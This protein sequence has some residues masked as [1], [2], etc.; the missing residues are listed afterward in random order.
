[1][2][3]AWEPTTAVAKAYVDQL[4]RS[5][6]IS[7]ERM[8]AIN[9]ALSKVDSLRTGKE[10]NAKAA[11]DQL[12]AVA[13]QVEADGKSK[14]GVDAKRYAALADTLRGRAARLR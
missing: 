6:S 3:V 5:K 4:N 11:L 10:G 8:R 7:A 13:A 14:S 2:K 9:E 1:P 12:E